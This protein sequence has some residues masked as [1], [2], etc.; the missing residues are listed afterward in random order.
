MNGL[1]DSDA[2]ERLRV[3]LVVSEGLRLQPYTDTVGKLTIGIGRNLTD[4]GISALEAY[5]LCDHDV[6]RASEVLVK[7]YPWVLEQDM[8]RRVVL[9]ELM[10]NMGP[11]GLG[12]FVNTLRAFERKDYSSA[13]EGLRQSKWFRQVQASRSARI[14]QMVLSGEFA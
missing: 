12:S 13:A 1:I 8:V 14:I 4:V 2:R 7:R 10:F 9:T 6:D 5:D 11:S 3:Y